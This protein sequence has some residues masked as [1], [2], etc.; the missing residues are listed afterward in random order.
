MALTGLRSLKFFFTDSSQT[1]AIGSHSVS[2][3]SHIQ[4]QRQTG[5]VRSRWAG[6]RQI[7]APPLSSVHYG[8]SR[9]RSLS[10]EIRPPQ[11]IVTMASDLHVRGDV[12]VC[13][14]VCFRL[15]HS[16]SD[17]HLQTPLSDCEYQPS[18]EHLR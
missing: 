9:Q 6:Y 7:P 13:V 1:L 18:T 3:M 17:R 11:N 5:P 4:R 8:S 12:Y 10:S 14:C 2:N 16:S 15:L